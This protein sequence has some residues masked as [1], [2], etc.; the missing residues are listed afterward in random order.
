MLLFSEKLVLST[1]CYWAV[2]G[3][4]LLT[5]S[6]RLIQIATSLLA[7]GPRMKTS[8]ISQFSTEAFVAT[9]LSHWMLRFHDGL[10]WIQLLCNVAA[11]TAQG[12]SELY[13]YDEALL[14]LP[15]S[16][17]QSCVFFEIVVVGQWL[18]AVGL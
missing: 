6:L 14:Q 17:L 3:E 10:V 8:R 16:P 15:P 11:G 7:E 18:P 12:A 4:E 2:R 13:H 1:S 5:V 9:G